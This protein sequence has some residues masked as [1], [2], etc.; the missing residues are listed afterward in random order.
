MFLRVKQNG[1]H[2]YL[3]LVSSERSAG[4]VRQRVIGT[5]GRRDWLAEPDT[6]AGLAASRNK[7]LRRAAVLTEQRAGQT[8]VRATRRL[9]PGLVFGRLWERLEVPAILAERLRGRKFGVPVER[10]IFLPVR[11]RRMTPA[12]GSSDRAAEKWRADYVLPGVEGLE[13]QHLYRA[14]AWLGSPRPKTQLAEATPLAPRGTKDLIEQA[15]FLRQ[16]DLFSDLS[17]VFCDPTSLYFEGQGGATLGRHG[18]SQDH[19]PDLRQMV[20]LG[21]PLSAGI[22]SAGTQPEPGAAGREGRAVHG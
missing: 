1:A 11:H 19:R 7:F 3:Q 20:V 22:R 13:L 5:R 18:P 10:A 16:R 2:E 14:M 9:G 21:R 4:Q 17:L 12:S 6:L 15:V 8:A